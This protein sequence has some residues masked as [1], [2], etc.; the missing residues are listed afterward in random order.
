[1]PKEHTSPRTPGED[2]DKVHQLVSDEAI[3]DALRTAYGT[4][5]NAA[6]LLGITARALYYRFEQNPEL[7]A[8]LKEARESLVD[9]ATLQLVRRMNEGSDAAIIFCL[10]TQGRDR[11]WEERPA[12][13]APQVSVNLQ[14][15]QAMGELIRDRSFR[16]AARTI[17]SSRQ[18]GE[19]G[20]GS[21][22]DEQA[23]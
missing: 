5:T 15:E 6:R 18:S 17:E 21:D 2:E 11:G 12:F 13:E 7:R 14:L 20:H 3:A 9:L 8:V 22:S 10:K 16:A 19:L 1:M 23:S 4:V